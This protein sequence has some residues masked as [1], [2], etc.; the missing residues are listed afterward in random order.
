VLDRVDRPRQLLDARGQRLRELLDR[1]AR[2]ADTPFSDDALMRI[3][4]LR[5]LTEPVDGIADELAGAMTG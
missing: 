1:R 4:V 5:L 3:P 2:R